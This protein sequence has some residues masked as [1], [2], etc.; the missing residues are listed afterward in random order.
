M[1]QSDRAALP[2]DRTAAIDHL[3]REYGTKVLHLAYSYLKDRHLA[4]DVAQ[5]VFIKAYRNWENFRGESS[6]YTWLYR[7]TVNLCRDKARSAWWRRL[8]PTDDPR[9]A[10]TPVEPDTAGDDPEEA[11]VLSDQRERLL[12][13]VMQLSDAYR[14]VIILYYYHDLTTVEIA[15]VT[16]QNENTV[17]TRLFRARAMLKQMLQKGGV[18]R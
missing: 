1:S 5:E 17:K 10:G 2:S 15:E 8:L 13:Y 18:A 7:I 14:E 4:E 16:G 11:V 3:M 12:D 9:A 6:A